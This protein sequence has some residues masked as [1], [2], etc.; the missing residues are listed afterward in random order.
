MWNKK[1]F[2]LHGRD[3]QKVLGTKIGGIVPL[4]LVLNININKGGH[5]RW[6]KKR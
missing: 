2:H 1:R 5:K 3:R 6:R 4:T